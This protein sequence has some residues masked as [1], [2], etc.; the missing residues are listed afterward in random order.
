[1][2]P[3]HRMQIGRRLSYILRGHMGAN[4]PVSAVPPS[5]IKF[6]T[7][8]HD[9]AVSRE[10][11]DPAFVDATIKNPNLADG[12]EGVAGSS[13][14]EGFRGSPCSAV[15]SPQESLI[16][17]PPRGGL[18]ATSG[19]AG[20]SARRRRTSPAARLSRRSSATSV[21]RS[22]TSPR[23]SKRRSTPTTKASRST[24]RSRAP[25]CAAS[26]ATQMI[27]STTSS[28]R[29][30]SESST[31]APRGASRGARARRRRRCAMAHPQ[32]DR[33]AVALADDDANGAASAR[34]SHAH[35]GFETRGQRPQLGEDPRLAGRE[36]LPSRVRCG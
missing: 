11:T 4:S 32:P 36:L 6:M 34:A 24:T 27:C 12:K 13:P 10:F 23:R 15:T 19:R 26:G 35:E 33:R 22:T 17:E 1:M 20:A 25:S 16:S 7:S 5:I 3:H 30:R 2:T 9:S 8:A 21:A 31:T 29:S 18:G 28:A 14:A